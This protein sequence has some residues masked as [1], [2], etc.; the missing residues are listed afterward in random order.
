MAILAG[1]SVLYSSIGEAGTQ[2]NRYPLSR[3]ARRAW[4]SCAKRNR[5]AL[6]LLGQTAENRPPKL[7]LLN[8]TLRLGKRR[9]WICGAEIVRFVDNRWERSFPRRRSLAPVVSMSGRDSVAMKAAVKKHSG[10]KFSR[11]TADNSYDSALAL[12]AVR[13]ATGLTNLS[14]GPV[15]GMSNNPARVQLRECSLLARQAGQ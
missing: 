14:R 7:M 13:M 5:R 4:R 8:R 15:H 6:C 12:F 2:A 10:R 1:T 11:Q 3:L 9:V